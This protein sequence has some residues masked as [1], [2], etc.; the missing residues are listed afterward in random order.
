MFEGNDLRLRKAV[1]LHNR[2]WHTHVVY[3]I[4]S[5]SRLRK[6]LIDSQSEHLRQ[7]PISAVER[8]RQASLD[9][10]TLA[11]DYSGQRK[12]LKNRISATQQTCGIDQHVFNGP[13]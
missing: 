8:A 4:Q 3:Q 9:S 10:I 5:E 2:H 12:A 13:V 7:R 1:D 6:Y 11:D